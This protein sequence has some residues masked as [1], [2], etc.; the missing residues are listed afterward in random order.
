MPALEARGIIILSA[1]SAAAGG[2][3]PAR[4][5][6]IYDF[7]YISTRNGAYNTKAYMLNT[8]VFV[9]AG[10]QVDITGTGHIFVGG[11]QVVWSNFDMGLISPLDSTFL[12]RNYF[13]D[14]A[15]YLGTPSALTGESVLFHQDRIAEGDRHDLDI[16]V[17]AQ[18]EGYV[19]IGMFDHYYA[20]NT[21]YHDFQLHVT[22][23][24]SAGLLLVFALLP[25]RRRR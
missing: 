18:S 5:D 10:E 7:T 13:G 24:P 4:G 17:F 8:G 23:E 6:S 25:R 20:D 22:P 3:C 12:I 1:L 15:T 11:G 9:H 2:L 19:Y 21:G 14:G 16:T